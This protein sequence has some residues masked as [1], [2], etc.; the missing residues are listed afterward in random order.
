MIKLGFIGMGNMGYAIAKSLSDNNDVSMCF[1]RRSTEE[2]KK[3][4]KEINAKYLASNEEVIANSDYVVL[5]IKP[6][7]FDGVFNSLNGLLKDK[8]VISLAPGCSI[9]Q[10]KE[11]TGS[12][13]VVRT[14]PNTPAMVGEG[15][16]GVSYEDDKLLDV[17]KNAIE[18]IF[19]SCGRMIKINENMMNGVVCASGSSP[20][21]VFMFIEALADSAV[22]CGVPRASAYELVA[23][24]VLGSAKLMLETGKHPAELKDMVCSPG[25]TTI[26]GVEKLE[27][28][29]FRGAI[30]EA[31]KACFDKCNNIK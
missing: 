28:N 2:G 25:G 21:Y 18:T 5:A 7:M 30:F 9:D 16:T 24:T 11:M 4:E 26:A 1:Y 14:M 17:E 31:T 22:K 6:Q 3:I 29:G 13:K 20:A 27:E 23:Q 15:M 12:D 19:N 10:L 8:V